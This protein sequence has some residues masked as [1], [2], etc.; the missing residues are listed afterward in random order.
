MQKVGKNYFYRR[1]PKKCDLSQK[2]PNLKKKSTETT[3]GKLKSEIEL[4]QSQEKRQRGEKRGKKGKKGEQMDN[5]FLPLQFENQPKGE[6][7]PLLKKWILR[8]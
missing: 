5:S 1:T 8:A 2:L 7:T 6:N 4:S 3:N